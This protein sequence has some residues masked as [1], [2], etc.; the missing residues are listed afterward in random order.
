MFESL[1]CE[2]YKLYAPQGNGTSTAE[3]ASGRVGKAR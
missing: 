1:F 2:K 3:A